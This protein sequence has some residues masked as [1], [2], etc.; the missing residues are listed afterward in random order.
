MKD[1]S[2][3]SWRQRSETERRE[4]LAEVVKRR[5]EDPER[6]TWCAL[7]REFGVERRTFQYELDPDF[8]ERMRRKQRDAGRKVRAQDRDRARYGRMHIVTDIDGRVL[9]PDE[10]RARREALPDD[11]R[12]LTSRLLG[13]PLPGRSARDQAVRREGEKTA[14]ER[15]AA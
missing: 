5:G 6:W 14:Q 13:D 15:R 11:T 12:S 8:R 7:A 4:T 9:S 3:P 1:T 2:K 10:L